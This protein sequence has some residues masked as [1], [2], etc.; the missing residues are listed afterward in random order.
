M[1]TR[2]WFLALPLW[3]AGL[4]PAEAAPADNLAPRA[5]RITASEELPEFPAR[6]AADGNPDTFWWASRSPVESGWI[7]FAWKA[8]VTVR[9]VVIR[10]I[11]GRGGSG[12]SR[13]QV[14]AWAGDAW[15]PAA[16]IGD[17]SA[18]L[19]LTIL[20]R[21]PP[22]SVPRLRIARLRG[23]VRWREVEI[24]EGPNPPFLDVRGNPAGE[25]LGVLTDAWGTAGIARAEVR[26]SG[27]AGGRPWAASAQTEPTGEFSLPMPV[28]LSGSVRFVA[29][30]PSGTAEKM[31]EAGDLHQGLV[32][33]PAGDASSILLTGK[34]RFHVDPPGGFE[35]PRFDDSSWPE[36]DV[37]SHW[38]MKG[39]RCESGLGGYR[40]TVRIPETWKGQR[41]R[42]AFD[43][44]YSGAEVWA[45]GRRAGSHLGG[46]NPFQLDLT[47]VARPGADVVIAVKVAEHTAASDDLDH[48]SLYADFPLA[49]IWRR[50]RLFAVPPVHIS[51]LHVATR[52]DAAYKDAVLAVD[53]T[54]VNESDTPA[55]AARANFSVLDSGGRE[56]A[57]SALQRID[58]AA[59]S[60]TDRLVEMPVTS[61]LH[62]EAEHP[63][64][65]LLRATLAN[66]A[67]PVEI[68]ERRIGFRDVRVQGTRLLINGA[69]VKLK[70][71]CHHDSHPT[72]G[73]AVTPELE[74][75]D[76]ELIKQ[77][78]LNAVRTS[79]YPPLPDLLDAA[80]QKG[81]YVEDEAS[82]CWANNSTDLRLL[83]LAKQFTAE[84][85]ERDRSHPSVVL[86][87][88]GN[89]SA[90]GPILLAAESLIRKSDS[91]RPVIGS[92][93]PNHFDLEVRHN[94]MDLEGM[95]SV[96]NVSKPVNWDES[97]GIFQ[98]I[99]G[100]GKE[101]WRD[102][103]YRDYYVVPLRAIM[104]EFFKSNVV[105][106]SFIWAW[107][108]D[109]FAVPGRSSEY[110]RDRT[111]LHALSGVYGM[112]GRGIA[113]DAPW[114]VIDG[115][116]RLKP[117]YWHIKNL[118]SPV[119]VDASAL[120]LPEQGRPLQIA[121]ENRYD[122]SPFSELKID[123]E[124]GGR[125]GTANSTLR[126]H[127]S[128]VLEIQPGF[129]PA[130][131]SELALRFT[132]RAGRI[133]QTARI[134]IGEKAEPQQQPGKGPL[135][136]YEETALAGRTLRV[137]GDGFEL[138]FSRATGQVRRAV[139]GGR[140]VLYQAPELHVIPADP[141]LAEFP[142]PQSWRLDGQ[143]QVESDPSR[144][145]VTAHGHYPNLAG[146]YKTTVD[147]SGAVEVSYDFTYTGPELNAREIGA[148]LGL[149][150][151]H[152]K[153]SWKR[154]GEWSD[155]PADHI[156]R[157]RGTATAHAR[158]AATFPPAWS[159]AEDDS[160]LGTN[161]FRSTKRNFVNASLEDAQGYGVAFISD[162]S[163]HLRASLESDRVAAFVND[164]MGGTFSRGEWRHF[165]RGRAIKTGDRIQGS[166]RLRLE[167]P[168]KR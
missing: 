144:V 128:G 145:V 65:Y 135:R 35:Q 53:F 5:A 166:V 150:L 49:G 55:S 84:L 1:R 108:D 97:L 102:P 100:D 22:M 69:P 21:F 114:G 80:D 57:N 15:K 66:T 25:I 82:F 29:A 106:G 75:Q 58:L 89:E 168:G 141:T 7:E 148:R 78:N 149:P 52:F 129:Q 23:F 68:V 110:G 92:W 36:I 16:T 111:P 17:G 62:W 4:L 50:A 48:M 26:A 2:A 91:T 24:Y 56:V 42:L 39:F 86:W 77:A 12:I 30:T 19:P 142:D 138:G 3:V 130:P 139:A 154:Q 45:N 74:T 31:V 33:A 54:V 94:P 95:A 27:T 73:R 158:H 47:G 107:S 81:I 109:L 64:L 125:R 85:V 162:G 20:A 123:W 134:R 99:W 67:E 143:I 61:P 38:I 163:Q 104:D 43:G 165:G 14:E 37:P 121:V 87:S 136:T 96:A 6:N 60:K 132:D 93:M 120:A 122:F 146:V 152:E 70:G 140:G 116:R 63:N 147:S 8:P 79:H 159:F 113:G 83:A 51:R 117:E 28:G 18:A 76:I 101:I 133:V 90:W 88:A 112:P 13:I 157:T 46:A 41:I 137:A 11:G 40:R 71:T 119:K 160:P 34:W 131:G 127:E 124:L 115:W 164:W 153:L 151:S 161:D 72:M 156:G 10:Q 118:H 9:E 126:Q 44:V 103:G 59:W 167:W 98:G 105:Q 155:Y 32:P